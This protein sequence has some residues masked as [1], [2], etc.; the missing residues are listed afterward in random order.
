MNKTLMAGIAAGILV[1][2][3]ILAPLSFDQFADAKHFKRIIQT[4]EFKSMQDPGKG[5]ELHKIAIIL[6]PA[7]NVVYSGRFTYSASVPVEVVVLQDIKEGETPAKIYT[8]DGQKK[9]ALSL[10]KLGGDVG[11]ATGSM[12]F[13][14]AALALHTLDGSD[15]T[16]QV[17]VHANARA[18]VGELPPVGMTTQYVCSDRSTVSD[19]TQCPEGP[20]A[21]VS[22]AKTITVSE[23]APWFQPSAL[24][25]DPGTPIV[26]DADET[27]SI[28]TITFVTRVTDLQLNMDE[29][30]TA[31]TF[32]I[33][34]PGDK[35]PAWTPEAG[36]YVYVC[37]IHPYMTGVISAGVPYNAITGA[38]GTD[39]KD[40]TVLKFA[41]WYPSVAPWQD[42]R[43]FRDAPATPGVGEVWVDTQFEVMAD[44]NSP[45]GRFGKP[46]PG[47]ITVVDA[48]NWEVKDKISE[49]LNNPHNLMD[50]PD[51]KYV[52]QSNWHDDY[53]TLIDARTKEV[54][55]NY[56]Q[57][58]P[59]PAH[60][61]WTEDNIIIA[62]ANAASELDLFDGAEV[63]D[64]SKPASEIKPMEIIKASLPLAG[65][66]GFWY[67]DRMISVP[68]HLANHMVIVSLDEKKE[69]FKPINISELDDPIAGDKI[70]PGIDLAS[71]L[72]PE[73]NG[74]RFWVTTE[75]L[76]SHSKLL[77]GRLLI[78]DI[79]S[80]VGGPTNPTQV[81]ILEVGSIPIQSPVSP[82]GRYVVTANAGGIGAKAMITVT[83]LDYNNPQN[84][85]VVATLPGYPG[86]HGVEYGFKKGGGLYAYV[87]SKFAPVL[88]V[89]DLTTMKPTL[90]GE[91]DL[92]NGWGGMGIMTMPSAAYYA[93]LDEHPHGKLYK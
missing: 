88:Q 86:S 68:Y 14:G 84:S 89:V 9:W 58:G 5:H 82:D 27:A 30:F 87:S 67:K 48:A 62:G 11:T 10:I 91:I 44:P 7:D 76:L 59:D 90:A 21:P 55:K 38:I 69:L 77:Q 31:K 57:T 50:S 71:Y 53:L 40:P 63:T 1:L 47:T 81:N 75:V 93:S 66:H 83:E 18:M 79:G 12:S 65:P 13:V 4:K 33:L 51:G 8:I 74:H 15:F 70:G 24:Q 2:G 34:S 3:L 78:Y 45:T 54:V 32:T 28:H 17:S 22:A 73:I 61:A 42:Q 37:A 85:K 39:E 49:G 56:I 60:V 43:P 19:P 6:P 29:E 80:A 20:V 92:G 64:P 41:P 26:W 35:S 16:A 72:G 23:W 25:V 46:W 52:I 36:V